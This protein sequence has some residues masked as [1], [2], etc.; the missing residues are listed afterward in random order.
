RVAGIEGVE[1]R[2]PRVAVDLRDDAIAGWLGVELSRLGCRVVDA[3]EAADL[4]LRAVPDA[5]PRLAV[6]P[7]EGGWIAREDGEIMIEVPGRF[8]GAMSVYALLVLPVLAKLSG[9]PMR[10][11]VLPVSIKIAS[12]I[13]SSD[14]VLLFATDTVLT[15][16][17]VG[18]MPL[19][20]FARAS[21]FLVVPPDNEGLDAGTPV[22]AIS[23]AEPFGFATASEE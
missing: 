22:A 10:E 16:L 2:V 14:L 18:E 19:R 21:H 5:G 12:A 1:V 23:L 13:G 17:S 9:V 11:V 3:G 7:G 8:D 4:R 15:P 6:R 20:A